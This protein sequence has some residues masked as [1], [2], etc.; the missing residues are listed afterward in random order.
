[1]CI[2]EQVHPVDIFAALARI[3]AAH[4]YTH[5]LR[6]CIHLHTEMRAYDTCILGADAGRSLLQSVN[7][8]DEEEKK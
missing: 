4:A 6:I 5:A 7:E 1:M 8:G 2:R 3:H